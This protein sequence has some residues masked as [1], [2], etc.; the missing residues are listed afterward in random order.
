MAMQLLTL[1]KKP[2]HIH[3]LIKQPQS[4]LITSLPRQDTAND[5]TLTHQSYKQC[6]QFI[7]IRLFLVF[8]TPTS[9][10]AVMDTVL[11]CSQKIVKCDGIDCIC[12][13]SIK[14]TIHLW[15][16]GLFPDNLTIAKVFSVFTYKID[17][18]LSLRSTFTTDCLDSLRNFTFLIAT[19]ELAVNQTT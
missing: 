10:T 19:N 14:E 1:K 9:S 6:S 8:L 12:I 3:I 16:Y 5:T 4:L 15:S 18:S 11:I 2:Q 7:T 17:S 13:S